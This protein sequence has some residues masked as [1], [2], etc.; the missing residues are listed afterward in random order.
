M[1]GPQRKAMYV[2]MFGGMV[3]LCVRMR[4]CVCVSDC[5]RVCLIVGLFVCALFLLACLIV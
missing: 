2:S 3:A 5:V 4:E 1:S